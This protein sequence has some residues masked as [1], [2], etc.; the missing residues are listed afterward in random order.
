M[1]VDTLGLEPVLRPVVE[2]KLFIGTVFVET[3]LH[4]FDEICELCVLPGV[5]LEVALEAAAEDFPSHEE[6]KLLDHAGSL[7]VSDT[8]NE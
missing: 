5:A 6:D 7:T 4:A 1:L 8:I 3:D 2:V